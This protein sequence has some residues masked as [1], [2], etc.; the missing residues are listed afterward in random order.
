MNKTSKLFMGVASL[1][2]L[3]AC[4]DDAPVVDGG[5]TGVVPGDG[6]TAYMSVVLSAPGDFGRSTDFEDGDD[7]T[8][9]LKPGDEHAI[10]NAKF[11]FFD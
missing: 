7:K 9:A 1:A 3:A 10:K 4:S 11:F 5:N 8:D 2:M 6:T